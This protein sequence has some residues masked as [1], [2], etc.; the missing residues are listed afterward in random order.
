MHRRQ[1]VFAIS[2]LAAT[3]LLVRAARIPPVEFEG[4]DVA[5]VRYAGG[6]EDGIRTVSARVSRWADAA[7]AEEFRQLVIAGA[8]SNLPMGEFYQS[9]P[10]AVEVPDEALAEP[11]T[12]IGWHTTVGAAGFVT[13][14]VLLAVR[15]DTLMWDLRVSG[16]EADEAADVAVRLAT[17][18]VAREPGDDLFALLPAADDVPEGLTLDF[19]MSPDGTFNAEGTPI[20]EP[21]QAPN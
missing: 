21:T 15:R 7:A 11:A 10:A 14:W 13:E 8:G 16:A 2:A 19:T 12:M 20:P 1:F 5:Q 18:L 9:E 3:P 4:E 6:D 17:D